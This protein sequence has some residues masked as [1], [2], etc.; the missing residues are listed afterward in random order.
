M[1]KIT[2]PTDLLNLITE[3]ADIK[4]KL[5]EYKT[6]NY[7]TIKSIKYKCDVCY[8]LKFSNKLNIC[9]KT[10]GSTIICIDSKNCYIF[11]NNNF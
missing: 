6:K 7:A 2:L 10:F 1:T 11:R 5:Q 9:M 8:Q 4:I 3:F